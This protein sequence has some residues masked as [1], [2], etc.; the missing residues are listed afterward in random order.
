MPQIKELREQLK[1]LGAAASAGKYVA[2]EQYVKK[3]SEYYLSVERT[4]KPGKSN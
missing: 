1:A 3:C 4:K 2:R